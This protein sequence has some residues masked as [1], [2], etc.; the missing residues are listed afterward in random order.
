[1]TSIQELQATHSHSITLLR[2]APDGAYILSHAKKDNSTQHT[3]F[4]VSIED[5]SAYAMLASQ[6]DSIRMTLNTTTTSR[7]QTR[8]QITPVNITAHTKSVLGR[9]YW[10]LLTNP[11]ITQL[12][13]TTNPLRYNQTKGL[14]GR[15]SE[16]IAWATT[17]LAH[18]DILTTDE[19]GL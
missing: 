14:T 6:N 8:Q 1:L 5:P 3:N 19:E 7:V 16:K 12:N 15:P 4:F 9:N 13:A 2:A 11:D 17:L 18:P 10:Q